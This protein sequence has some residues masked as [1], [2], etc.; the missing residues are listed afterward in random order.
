M[1]LNMVARKYDLDVYLALVHVS[2]YM[3]NSLSL[4][5]FT[6]DDT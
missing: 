2:A 4:I 5:C 3:R 1:I 6:Q